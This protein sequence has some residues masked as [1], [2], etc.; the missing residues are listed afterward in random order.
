VTPEETLA[1]WRSMS[2]V[3][4]AR[5]WQKTDRAMAER[6]MSL[7]EEVVKQELES[8]RS[9]AVREAE[10]RSALDE[11]RR[12]MDWAYFGLSVF[13]VVAGVGA[14]IVLGAVAGH[15][16]DRG[17]N[18]QGL[19]IF[20]SGAGAVAAVFAGTGI[21]WRLRKPKRPGGSVASSR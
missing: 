3:A 12:R 1:E 18:V 11:H 17:A 13:G 7:A 9:A 5:A 14:V 21:T 16:A 19:G 10:R 2:V 4:Q 8:V 20:A 6:V 15:Y